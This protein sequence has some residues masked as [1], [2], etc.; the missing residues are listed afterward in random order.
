MNTNYFSGHMKPTG[1]R[2]GFTLVEL[3]VVIAVM[4]IIAALLLP[5]LARAKARVTTIACLNNLK[6]QQVCWHLYTGDNDDAV[7]PN[8]SFYSLSEPNTS[9]TPTLS[10]SG[11]S[12]CPGVAPLDT[13]SANLASGVLYPYNHAP[14]IYHCPGDV[15][16]VTGQPGLLR[17][18]SYCMSISLNCDDAVGCFRKSTQIISPGP[19]RLFVTIDTQEQDIWDATFGIFSADSAYA[20]DWL[21]LPADRHQQGANLAFADGHVEHWH[22]QAAKKFTSRWETAYSTADLA[23]LHRLQSATKT[24]LD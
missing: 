24:G 5:A 23:D 1:V 19:S 9:A 8:N 3:L 2:N 17:T 22:W 11:A 21:D 14:G 7:A 13:T 6:Q 18:R 12:W 15:S 16:T 4:G 10:E 20:S